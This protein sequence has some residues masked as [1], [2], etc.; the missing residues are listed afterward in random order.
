MP[1]SPSKDTLTELNGLLTKLPPGTKLQV[2]LPN[3]ET[4]VAENDRKTKAQ[5]IEE[6]PQ[7]R[8]LKGRGITISEAAEK[9][10]VPRTTIEKWV[11]RSRDVSFVDEAS[12]PKLID[13]AEVALC[14]GI[15]KK[16]KK[17]A[18]I[19]NI[20]FFDEEGFLV[21]NVKHPHRSRRLKQ[22]A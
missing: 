1:D 10:G 9:Y 6:N 4:L 19:P 14:A 5:L 12:Y 20:P 17:E 16:R 21:E 7:L 15:Y 22:A 11:Y 2:T 3:G 8:A 13:E 18:V